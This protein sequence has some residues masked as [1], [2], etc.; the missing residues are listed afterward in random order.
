M[1]YKVTDY[2]LEHDNP[3]SI[4]RKLFEDK[5]KVPK[6]I[7]GVTN[8]LE[9]LAEACKI[10][11]GKVSNAGLDNL[12]GV[13]GARNSSG[14]EQKKI[15]VLSNNIV[16]NTL[17]FCGDVRKSQKLHSSLKTSKIDHNFPFLHSL[18]HTSLALS[19]FIT[20]F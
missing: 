4:K 2:T 9:T 8:I 14:D 3:F 18:A 20:I 17:R 13:S 19:S 7:R 15:D 10:I 5:Q 16:I 12:Y 1:Q 6:D 11:G